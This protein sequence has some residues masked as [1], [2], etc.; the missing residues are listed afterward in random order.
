MISLRSGDG[1]ELRVALQQRRLEP[2][3]I[4]LQ[5]SRLGKTQHGEQHARL[6]RARA[7][8]DAIDVQCAKRCEVIVEI[9][10]G[11]S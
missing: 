4:A 3:L 7:S 10:H 9:R 11:R 2:D 8:A 1:E 6:V 5:M